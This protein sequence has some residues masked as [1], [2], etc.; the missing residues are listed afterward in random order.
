MQAYFIE[1]LKDF[2][3][4][5]IG[6]KVGVHDQIWRSENNLTDS[7]LRPCGFGDRTHLICGFGDRTHLICLADQHLYWVEPSCQS[8][9]F[10]CVCVLDNPVVLVF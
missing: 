7:L 5:L 4:V 1:Q 8:D 3:Y 6:M 2:L 10:F 9:S